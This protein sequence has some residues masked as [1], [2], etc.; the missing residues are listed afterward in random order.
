[1]AAPEVAPSLVEEGDSGEEEDGFAELL[2]GL[3]QVSSLGGLLVSICTNAVFQ[4]LCALQSQ[5][6]FVGNLSRHFYFVQLI[7]SFYCSFVF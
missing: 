1:M 3:L 2:Q 7:C 5:G 4:G 6:S